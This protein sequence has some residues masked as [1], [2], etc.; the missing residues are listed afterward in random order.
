MLKTAVYSDE[1]LLSREGR[2]ARNVSHFQATKAS[3][4]RDYTRV[5]HWLLWRV[6]IQQERCAFLSNQLS[7]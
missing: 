3:Y 2:T 1:V 6:N 5:L 4:M 7:E